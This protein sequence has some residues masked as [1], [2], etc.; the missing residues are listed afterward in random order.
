MPG[1]DRQSAKRIS[2]TV[3]RDER[4]IRGGPSHRARYTNPRNTLVFFELLEELEQWSTDPVRAARKT[5]D[6]SANSGKGGF[7]VDCEDIVYVGD[8]NEVGHNA[9]IGGF[10][11]AEM[12]GRDNEPEWV[13]VIIDL[14]CPDDE[15]GECEIEEPPEP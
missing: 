10:G 12:H 1:F 8:Y 2:R 6:P 4:A 11:A 5:W 13:G 3:R 7:E 14:C 9:G 15:Q